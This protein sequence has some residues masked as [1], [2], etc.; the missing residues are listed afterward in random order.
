MADD[1]AI[2]KD[3]MDMYDDTDMSQDDSGTGLHQDQ[4]DDTDMPL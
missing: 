4:E 1:D 2:R 3:D